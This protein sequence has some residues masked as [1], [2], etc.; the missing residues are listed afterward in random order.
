VFVD[1][2]ERLVFAHVL[3]H[4]GRGPGRVVGKLGPVVVVFVR[5]ADVPEIEKRVRD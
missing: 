4:I 2:F 5:A 3:L 1:G